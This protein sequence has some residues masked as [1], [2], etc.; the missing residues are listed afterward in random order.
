LHRTQPEHL[1]KFGPYEIAA[2]MPF[3]DEL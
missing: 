1:P 3:P 2:A